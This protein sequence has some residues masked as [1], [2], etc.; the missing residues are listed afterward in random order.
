M[1]KCARE[2]VLAQEEL[3]LTGFHLVWAAS[4]RLRRGSFCPSHPG[5]NLSAQW[6][7]SCKV[8]GRTEGGRAVLSRK[9]VAQAA[10]TRRSISKETISARM[11]RWNSVLDIHGGTFTP[12]LCGEMQYPLWSKKNGVRKPHLMGPEGP[13][14]W[15]SSGP[16]R[17]WH[18]Q[19]RAIPSSGAGCKL[20]HGDWC[21]G[22]GPWKAG[23]WAGSC[24]P[25]EVWVGEPVLWEGAVLPKPWERSCAAFPPQVKVQIP[26]I[27][28]QTYFS[29]AGNNPRLFFSQFRASL[30]LLLLF[31]RQ[32]KSSMKFQADSEK[33]CSCYRVHSS[34]PLVHPYAYALPFVWAQRR[35]QG[36]HL[37][38]FDWLG[39]KREN[40]SF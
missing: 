13:Y 2:G 33:K 26:Q 11:K 12:V 9:S 38:L 17:F 28:L 4:L 34:P 31:H 23:V 21:L 37:L 27:I 25:G 32:R 19:I 36:V 15:G 40:R 18:G 1:G 6:L 14:W 29:H 10:L 8:T 7:L 3:L 22:A 39:D 30:P 20:I 16:G 5:M 24:S 35:V